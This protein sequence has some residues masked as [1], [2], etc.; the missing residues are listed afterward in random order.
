MSVEGLGALPAVPQPARRC[1]HRI[2]PWLRWL[3]GE[4]FSVDVGCRKRKS[5]NYAV[6]RQSEPISVRPGDLP[7][8]LAPLGGYGSALVVSGQIPD[9]QLELLCSQGTLPV[10]REDRFGAEVCAIG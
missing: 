8:R 5:A 7:D 3:F 9:V 6:Q 2:E 10:T 4:Y 1:R